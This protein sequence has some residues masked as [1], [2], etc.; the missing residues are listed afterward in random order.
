MQQAV[1]RANFIG[2]PECFNL[3]L[4]CQSINAAFSER[5]YGCFL[6]GSALKRKDFRD[7][8]VRVILKDEEF[9][10]LFPVERGNWSLDPLWSLLC[11]AISGWLSERTGLKIDFQ[12][13]RQTDA[14]K[15]Y[16][17]PRHALGMFYRQET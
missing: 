8:D 6:V 4:A 10:R 13:Q 7:V 1:H 17:G 15:E 2:A 5:S 9:D 12:I 14:N 3:N 16:D 11:A